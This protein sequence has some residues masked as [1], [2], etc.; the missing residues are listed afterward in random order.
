MNGSNSVLLS[1]ATTKD[2]TSADGW[3]RHGPV[4]PDRPGSKSAALLTR[5]SPPHFLFWGDSNISIAT[6]HDLLNYTTIGTLLTCVDAPPGR[7][8]SADAP[9]R[10]QAEA[11]A[12]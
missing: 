10:P 12:L 7:V 5:Q 1:L 6:T 9:P 2:P 3:T 4:F 8:R 11:H